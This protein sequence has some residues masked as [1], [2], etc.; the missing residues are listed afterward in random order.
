[1]ASSSPL[2]GAFTRRVNSP[3]AGEAISPPSPMEF[4]VATPLQQQVQFTGVASEAGSGGSRRS[5]ADGL[6]GRLDAANASIAQLSLNWERH[7]PSSQRPLS[8]AR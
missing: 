4:I 3:T 1:M 7:V 2:A 6:Q 8:S 5:E